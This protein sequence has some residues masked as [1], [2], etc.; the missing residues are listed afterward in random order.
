MNPELGPRTVIT[1][2]VSV[3]IVIIGMIALYDSNTPWGHAFRM[4]MRDIGRGVEE[5]LMGF[6]PAI[7]MGVAWMI[8]TPIRGK[9]T[10]KA[11]HGL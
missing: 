11:R 7:F 10:Y 9:S 8:A 4:K 6:I 1:A 3:G 5:L 2:L